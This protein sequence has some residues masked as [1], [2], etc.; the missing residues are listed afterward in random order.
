MET[1]AVCVTR[2]TAVRNKN[3]AAR[4][5]TSPDTNRTGLKIRKRTRTRRRKT[6]VRLHYSFLY[7][8]GL[9]L[10]VF[11]FVETIKVFDGN[12]S[13]RRRIFRPVTVPRTC[14][15]DQLLSASLRSLHISRDPT[16]FYVTDL[17]AP[18]GDEVRC[19]DPQPVMSLH[20]I[21]GKRPAI[22]LRFR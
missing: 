6:K 17:Y 4:I 13:L 12:Y 11:F 9:I 16:K 5:E 3:A 21:E 1:K 19:Q 14:S 20:R 15:V 8:R 18:G 2:N 22:Y 10:L 7:D